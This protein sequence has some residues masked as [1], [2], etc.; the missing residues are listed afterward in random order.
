MKEDQDNNVIVVTWDFSH[1]SE[2][3]LAHAIKIAYIMGYEIKLLH[4]AESGAASEKIEDARRRM[5]KVCE[6]TSKHNGIVCKAV[7]KEGSLLSAISDYAKE[8]NTQLVVMGTH[9]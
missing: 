7:V 4:I 2:Y 1:V 8:S 9:E 6:D 3:A 5:T